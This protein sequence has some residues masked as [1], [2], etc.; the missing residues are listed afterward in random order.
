K[1]E[2]KRL[3]ELP[4]G[5]KEYPDASAARQV[6]GCGRGRL[7]ALQEARGTAAEGYPITPGGIPV[8]SMTVPCRGEPLA[9]IDLDVVL[10]HDNHIDGSC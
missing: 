5:V 1:P 4:T 6:R 3:H 2:V 7:A 8:S 10:H 9:K